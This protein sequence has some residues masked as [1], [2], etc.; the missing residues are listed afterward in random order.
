MRAVQRGRL[1]PLGGIDNRRSLVALDNLVS[2]IVAC[3]EHPGAANQSFLVS[4]G[5]DL[6]TPELVRR[7]AAAMHR[8]ARLI[9]VPPSLLLGAASLL[10]RRAAAERLCGSLQVDITKAR[11]LLGWSPPISVNEG[12]RRAVADLDRA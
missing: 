12:M 5:E 8:P 7:L 11:T 1:L 6:S 10:G 2:F 9:P 3:V 4:D